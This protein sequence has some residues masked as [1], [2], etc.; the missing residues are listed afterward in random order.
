MIEA[1]KGLLGEYSTKIVVNYLEWGGKDEQLAKL[2]N[3]GHVFV[4]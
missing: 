4:D 3:F 2:L 1:G